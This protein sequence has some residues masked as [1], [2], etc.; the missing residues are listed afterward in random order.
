M[1]SSR[2]KFLL[3]C[4]AITLGL[5]APASAE[6][7]GDAVERVLSDH[8]SVRAAQANESA[9]DREV[10]ENM[11]GYFPSLNLSATGGRVYADNSVSRGTVTT[12]GAAYAPLWEGSATL[13]QLIFDGFETAHRSRAARARQMSAVFAV[14]D[15]REQ[16]A[17]QTV[18]SYLDVMRLRNNVNDIYGHRA[19]VQDYLSR[20]KTAVE[21]GA[22]D[23]TALMQASDIYAQLESSVAMMKSQLEAAEAT[24]AQLTGA[25]P[26]KH[27][28]R[29]ESL[30]ADIPDRVEEA[31]QIAWDV[32]P[33]LQASGLTERATMFDAVAEESAY[34]PDV[35]GELSYLKKDTL[36]VVG[37]EVIDAKAVVRMSWDFSLAGGDV[38]RVNKAKFRQAEARANLEAQQRAIA[39]A[40]RAAYAERDNARRQL[41]IAQ[42]RVK[43]N[44]DLFQTYK[45][46]FEGARVDLLQLMQSDNALFNAKL[47]RS[48]ADAG[49]LLANYSVL[50]SMGRLQR[51][52][53]IVVASAYDGQG[54]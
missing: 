24:Y 41:E 32:H 2:Q 33:T 29:P 17:L 20:I 16:L 14:A 53:N 7:L 31:I 49:M 48:N 4:S 51:T 1:M 50:A 18:A 46:Q 11:S 23:N 47:A 44:A 9:L 25:M 36:D 42:D 38:A 54:K 15:I 34:F 40:V 21:Q 12:R 22:V 5:A 45:A 35:N 39:R 52:M 10:W 43:Y 30:V 19:L 28:E 27:I 26:D 3:F 8:P 6:T 37:G 13:T